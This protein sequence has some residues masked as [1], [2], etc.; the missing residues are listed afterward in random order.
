V[1][2]RKERLAAICLVPNSARGSFTGGGSNDDDE[3]DDDE[4]Y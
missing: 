4:D 3:D 1:W 2:E